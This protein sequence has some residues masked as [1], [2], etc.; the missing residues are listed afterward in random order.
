[1]AADLCPGQGNDSGDSARRPS[2][3][4]TRPPA[5]SG[6]QLAPAGGAGGG[7]GGAGSGGAGDPIIEVMSDQSVVGGQ[8][9]S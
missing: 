5:G 7:G 6:G 8:Q 1:M 3:F 4:T 9:N 2:R